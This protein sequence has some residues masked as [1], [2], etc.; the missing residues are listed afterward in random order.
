LKNYLK[1]LKNRLPGNRIPG[2]QNLV[3]DRLAMKP[4]KIGKRGGLRLISY[5]VADTLSVFPLLICS[6]SDMPNPPHEMVVGE[7]SIKCLRSLL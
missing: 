6:K 5:N 7:F 2:H 3:K 1:K 4:Y